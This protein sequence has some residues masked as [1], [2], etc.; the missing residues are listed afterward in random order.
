MNHSCTES[1]VEHLATHEQPFHFSASGLSNVYL[2][3]VKHYTC[4]CGQTLADIPAIK[5]LMQLIARDLVRKKTSLI[6]EEIRFLRKRLGKKQTDFSREI[7]IEPETL[8]RYENDKQPISEAQDK[9][10]RIY[11]LAFSDDPDFA[12]I[13]KALSELISQQSTTSAP[14]KIVAQV[15]KQDEWEDVE[16]A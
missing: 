6:G 4:E 14:K 8:S 12:E 11:Y 15:S 5:D 1:R 16:V 3:G 7:G 10:I 2:I 13:R 9:L